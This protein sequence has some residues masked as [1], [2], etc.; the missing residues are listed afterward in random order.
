[1][2]RPT[3]MSSAAAIAL[4]TLPG[5]AF[6]QDTARL[7][8]RIALLEAQLTELRSE[9]VTSRTHQT[10]EQAAVNRDIIRIEQQV[11]APP[12][13][14]AAP[15]DGF[16]IGNNTLRIGG[17]VKADFIA[18]NYDG[19]DPANGDLLREFLSSR[20]NPDRRRG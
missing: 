1:M 16:R 12:A 11:T 2:I 8:G 6:A 5:A 15:A 14:A 7:E 17:F 19:G 4:L 18:S 13:P 9:V 10:A 20:V 3:L